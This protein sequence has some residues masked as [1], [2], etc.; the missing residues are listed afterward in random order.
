MSQTDDFWCSPSEQNKKSA[1][2]Q[3]GQSA[4]AAVGVISKG[5]HVCSP[6]R[7][8]A[9]E[10]LPSAVCLTGM[11]NLLSTSTAGAGACAPVLAAPS[12]NQKSSDKLYWAGYGSNG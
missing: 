2:G 10:T 5:A 7:E 4:R 8:L 6:F 1:V 3:R 9:S 12:Q 11:T